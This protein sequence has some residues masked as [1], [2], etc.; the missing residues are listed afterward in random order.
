MRGCAKEVGLIMTRAHRS[1][2][3][4]SAILLLT[5]GSAPVRAGKFHGTAT[6]FDRDQ[7][8]ILDSFP[9]ESGAKYKSKDSDQEKKLCQADFRDKNVGLCPKTWSTSPGTI[10]YDISQ[11]KYAGKPDLFETE[12]CPA[13][14]KLK[15]RVA[16]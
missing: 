6:K 14:R 9:A 8:F 16:G 2:L 1:F 4:P 13:Q 11:S 15:G 3:I 12:Y 10:V 5:I 7:C